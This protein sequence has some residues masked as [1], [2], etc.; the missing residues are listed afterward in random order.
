MNFDGVCSPGPHLSMTHRS[1]ADPVKGIRMILEV[2][3]L[4]ERD[5]SSQT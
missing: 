1:F 4:A 3:I 2:D 5:T